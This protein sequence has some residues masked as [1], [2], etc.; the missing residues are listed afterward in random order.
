MLRQNSARVATVPLAAT[1]ALGQTPLSTGFTYQGTLNQPGQPVNGS[2]NFV[3]ALY[4]ALGGGTLIGSQTLNGVAVND[5]LFMV[6]L[7]ANNELGNQAFSRDRRWLQISVNGT[8]LTPRQE[9]TAVPYALQT[10]GLYVDPNL[11]VSIGAGGAL[12]RVYVTE[13]GTGLPAVFARNT[14]TANAENFGGMFH[15]E[16]PLGRGVFGVSNVSTG[17]GVGVWGESRSPSGTGVY[18]SNAA[19]SGDAHGV[20]GRTDSNTGRA[21]VGVAGSTT[22]F[23]RGG[24]FETASPAGNGV[25]A[26]ATALSGTSYGIWSESFSTAGVGVRGEGATH[27]VVGLSGSDSGRGV[28]GFATHGLGTTYGV[29]GESSGS[30]GRGV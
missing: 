11:R 19:T 13:T 15:I 8:P 20:Y 26:R 7:N 16:S 17:S 18:E 27:G 4:D 23:A 6:V 3:F 30:S 28:A 29:Y 22:G 21:V 12:A 1:S 5:G 2:A 14:S 9:I 10:R 24:H 25:L